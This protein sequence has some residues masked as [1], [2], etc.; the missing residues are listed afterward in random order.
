MWTKFSL[1][2][3]FIVLTSALVVAVVVVLT[4]LT[5]QR[6]DQFSE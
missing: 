1:G 5:I 3:Q 4:V 2:T 6:A